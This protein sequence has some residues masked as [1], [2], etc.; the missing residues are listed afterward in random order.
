MRNCVIAY[1]VTNKYHNMIGVYNDIDYLTLKNRFLKKIEEHRVNN[2]LN[3]KEY[4]LQ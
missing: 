2:N 3:L 1:P 4:L